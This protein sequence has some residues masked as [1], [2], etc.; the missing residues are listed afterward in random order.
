MAAARHAAVSDISTMN[1]DLLH[2]MASAAPARHGQGSHSAAQHSRD[3]HLL[4]PNLLP[5]VAVAACTGDA[6]VQVSGRT[7]GLGSQMR[8]LCPNK[9]L[10]AILLQPFRS[11][12]SAGATAGE[13]CWHLP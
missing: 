1:V 11:P 12:L 2:M 4:A 5:G 7:S 6:T 3:M 13:H 10:R 8:R 9:F